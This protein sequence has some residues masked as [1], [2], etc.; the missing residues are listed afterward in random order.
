MRVGP[1]ITEKTKTQKMN[2]SEISTQNI[3]NLHVCSLDDNESK[4]INADKSL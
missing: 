2:N 4:L 1:V 3:S